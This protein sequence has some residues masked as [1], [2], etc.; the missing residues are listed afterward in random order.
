M[1]QIILSTQIKA[2][3]SL[4]FDLARS[5]DLHKISTRHTKEQAIAGKTS[6][7]IELGESVTWRAKHLGIYQRLTSKITAFNR[8][9]Y[10]TDE[11]LSGAFKSFTHQHLFEDVKEETIMTDIFDYEAPWGIFGEMADKLFLKNYMSQLLAKR[12]ALIKDFAETEKWKGIVGH[13]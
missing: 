1:S 8:P 11:M 9:N 2:P 7:L 12:N 13:F 10:F 6:G 4:V 3:R 5:I